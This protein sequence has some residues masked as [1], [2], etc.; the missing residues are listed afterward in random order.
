MRY[1]SEIRSRLERRGAL[2]S[3][4]LGQHI[5]VDGGILDLVANQVDSGSNVLE[6]GSGPGNITERIA[7]RAGKV[8]GIEI[9]RRFQPLLDEVQSARP[10]VEIIYKDALAVDFRKIV[11]GGI[12]RGAWQIASNPP[13]HISEPLLTKI[14]DLPIEDATLVVGDQLARRMQIVNPADSEFSKTSLITQTFFEPTVLSHV[15]KSS[16]YPQP[17]TDATIV[18]LYPRDKR[19]LERNPGRAILR[20]LFLSER[21]NPTVAKVIKESTSSGESKP[22]LSKTENHRLERRQSRQEMRQLTHDWQSGM[23]LEHGR[24]NSTRG[25]EVDKLDLPQDILSRPFSRL[26]NQD[27]RVLTAAL[28]KRYS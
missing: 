12:I 17:R 8:V 19:E 1:E 6:I 18:A 11:N 26:D 7:T 24:N 22:T 3:E 15:A 23:G 16:F 14:V 4:Q 21:K 9:D 13:F 27:L 20:N 28:K 10:N 25:S 5:I 2:L